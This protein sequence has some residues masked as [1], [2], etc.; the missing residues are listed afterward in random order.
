M[1]QM[2]DGVESTHQNVTSNIPDENDL[3]A[4]AQEVRLFEANHRH[5]LYLCHQECSLPVSTVEAPHRK[6]RQKDAIRSAFL[7]SGRPLS[8]EETLRFAQKKVKSISLATIYRN[9]GTLVEETWLSPVD[10]PGE[11]TRYEIAVKQH[12][13]HFHCTDC[14]KLF[15]VEGC[16]VAKTKLP[17]G[18]RATSHQLTYSGFCAEC[19]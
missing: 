5:A 18:F 3:P 12:H 14:G 6:T 4:T 8:P 16:S 15:P 17:R 19:R 11:A 1:R 9:I 7:E 2:S 10:V 13:H